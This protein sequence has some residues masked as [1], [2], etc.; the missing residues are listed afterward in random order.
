MKMEDIAQVAMHFSQLQATQ[1]FGTKSAFDLHKARIKMSNKISCEHLNEYQ[2]LYFVSLASQQLVL[3]KS[4]DF[5]EAT[6]LSPVQVKEFQKQISLIKEQK[7]KEIQH[8]ESK[9]FEVDKVIAK[10]FSKHKKIIAHFE[11]A[12][13]KNQALTNEIK[14]IEIAKHVVKKLKWTSTLSMKLQSI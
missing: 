14:Q 13:G 7:K 4:V 10:L 3:N 11:T 2:R 8:F 6:S 5:L 12:Q 9:V 1:Q